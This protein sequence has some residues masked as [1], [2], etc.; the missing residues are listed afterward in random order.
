MPADVAARL[1]AARPLAEQEDG[2]IVGDAPP[3]EALKAMLGGTTD[4]P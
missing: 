4:A 2:R 1:T 3:P